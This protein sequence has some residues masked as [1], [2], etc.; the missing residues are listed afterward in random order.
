ME[1]T[2]SDSNEGGEEE[3]SEQT[4]SIIGAANAILMVVVFT[5]VGWFALEDAVY[6]VVMGVLGGAGSWLFLPWFLKLQAEA[7]EDGSLKAAA[8]RVDES[9]TFGM[10]GIGLETGAMLMLIAGMTL[11]EPDLVIG[12]AAGL[13][14]VALSYLAGSLIFDL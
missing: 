10:I 11:E 5:A 4:I 14:P 13:L 8:K 6:G 1:A 3:F 7:D 9:T 12:V 2:E